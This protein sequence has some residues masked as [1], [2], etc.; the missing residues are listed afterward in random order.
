MY[1]EQVVRMVPLS[2]KKYLRILYCRLRQKETVALK[3]GAICFLWYSLSF[4]K[5]ASFLDHLFL[6]PL[7]RLKRDC[8]NSA[9]CWSRCCA[10]WL[11]SLVMHLTERLRQAPLPH[12]LLLNC[13]VPSSAAWSFPCWQN[14]P[15][16][17][18]CSDRERVLALLQMPGGTTLYPSW[19]II[20]H[21]C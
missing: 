7:H 2:A 16:T 18:S 12:S 1:M 14:L 21:S 11:P 20:P 13:F 8:I 3:Y 15:L 19:P 6:W 10:S 5:Q 9:A 4:Y 17:L